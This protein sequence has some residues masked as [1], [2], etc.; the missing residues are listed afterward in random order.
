MK[1]I[2][3]RGIEE[4]YFWGTQKTLNTLRDMEGLPCYK[5]IQKDIPQLTDI[6]FHISSLAHVTTKSGLDGILDSGG[7]KGGEKSL[8]W[9]GLAIDHDDIRAAED[10]YLEKLF[11]DRTPEQRQMQQ[12]FLSKFTTSPAF[13]KASRYGNF[14]FT[15]SLSDLLMM[16]RQQICGGE[17]PVLRVYG[18][19]VYKQEIM[20]TV[21]VH[22]PG[23]QELEK[24]PALNNGGEDVF[25]YQEGTMDWHAQ[26]VSETH[27]F[28]PVIH[29]P[30]VVE[31]EPFDCLY[32]YDK[33]FVWDH[34]TL[35]FHLPEGQT[36]QVDREKLIENLTACEAVDPFLGV[37]CVS[38]SYNCACNCCCLHRSEAEYIVEQKRRDKQSDSNNST[39]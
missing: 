30:Q 29:R 36:L 4:T 2:N 31:V 37:R 27:D 39:S 17:E 33:W 28:Q 7:F 11:P 14:R 26:A 13:R 8:L 9:W 38:N 34:V 21:L 10:R 1:R 35:A 32:E 3:A 18:T 15:F 25:K 5:N 24:Y 22:S 20:Y 16:Y 23:V 6:E 19:T 12:P